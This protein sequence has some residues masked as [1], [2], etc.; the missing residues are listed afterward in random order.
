MNYSRS[1][2]GAIPREQDLSILYLGTYYYLICRSTMVIRLCKFIATFSMK[3]LQKNYTKT[4]VMVGR[5]L[6]PTFRFAKVDDNFILLCCTPNIRCICL[7]YNTNIPKAY[8]YDVSLRHRNAIPG[9]GT[10][11]IY[12]LLQNTDKSLCGS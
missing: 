11:L 10:G 1:I 12:T 7:T 6:L 8:L 2:L 5:Y 4:M 3:R 9:Y